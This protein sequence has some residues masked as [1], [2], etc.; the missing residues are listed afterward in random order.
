MELW[1]LGGLFLFIL[2]G[3]ILAGYLFVLM[4][5]SAGAEHSAAS[6]QEVVAWAL[7]RLGERVPSLRRD[8]QDLRLRLAA[9]GYRW[10]SVVTMFQGG[11]TAVA[12]LFGLVTGWAVA[13]MR[14]SMGAAVAPALCAMGFGYIL[15]DRILAGVIKARARRLRSGLP[16]ALDLLV[17]GIEAGQPLDHSIA[18]TARELRHAHPDLSAELA[19]VQIEMQLGTSRLDALRNMADRNSEPELRKLATL[20]IESDRCGSSPAPALHSH[21]KYLRTRMRQQANEAARKL[22]VKLV[23]P[24]FFLIMPSLLLVTLG[25]AVIQMMTQ[26][27]QLTG[28]TLP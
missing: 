20:I 27:A 5:A 21:A 19:F 15:P 1:Y 16:S 11:R 9:A 7:K 2:G 22:G 3:V 4:P 17:L 18:E 6:T 28:D 8:G 10:P 25:P 12:I 26:F 23:F 14:G 24:V 13:V